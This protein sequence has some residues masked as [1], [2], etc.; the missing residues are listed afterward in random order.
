MDGK[1]IPITI[2]S[3]F[4]SVPAGFCVVEEV[5]EVLAVLVA[6]LVVALLVLLELL[7][8]IIP[9]SFCITSDQSPGLGCI[10]KFQHQNPIPLV[11]G[12]LL[13]G[14]QVLLGSKAMSR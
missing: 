14:P 2:F 13:F 11:K 12:T 8:G 5:A 1:P 4:A 3:R 9:I 7:F 6:A 10:E